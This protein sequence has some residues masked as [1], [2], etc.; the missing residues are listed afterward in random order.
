MV[1]TRTYQSSLVSF[2]ALSIILYGTVFPPT[3]RR[4]IRTSLSLL[5]PCPFFSSVLTNLE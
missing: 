5:A 3:F 4:C 2:R 1:I